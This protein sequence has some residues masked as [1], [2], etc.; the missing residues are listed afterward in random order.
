MRAAIVT[1]E[2]MVEASPYRKYKNNSE[3]FVKHN[4][5]LTELKSASHMS[6]HVANKTWAHSGDALSVAVSPC[7]SCMR[8][9]WS[10]AR[11]LVSNN[12][13]EMQ[14]ITLL[15]LVSDSIQFEA[16]GSIAASRVVA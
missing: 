12:T 11:S 6:I 14:F 16:Y 13:S 1:G 2:G 5:K 9:S 4:N 15:L 8:T 7:S 10:T 3:L